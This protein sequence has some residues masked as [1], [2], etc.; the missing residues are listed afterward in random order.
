M[1]RQRLKYF[2]TGGIRCARTEHRDC[3]GQLTDG[4]CSGRSVAKRKETPL[5][6][7]CSH[8]FKTTNW[9]FFIIIDTLH[10]HFT[11]VEWLT[12]K[13]QYKD[14]GYVFPP[15]L[16]PSSL[17]FV[18]VIEVHTLHSISGQYVFEI[19]SP[20]CLCICAFG[21][22]AMSVCVTGM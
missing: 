17:C 14:G 13:I 12:P 2:N 9:Q 6:S 22:Q 5:R 21:L 19:L 18:S 3:R 8:I 1:I 7:V 4:S 20:Q 11:F 15:L 16:P 10:I